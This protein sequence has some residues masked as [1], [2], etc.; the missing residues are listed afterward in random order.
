M[1][2]IEHRT[3]EQYYSSQRMLKEGVAEYTTADQLAM[4]VCLWP[5]LVLEQYPCVASVAVSNGDTRGQMIPDSRSATLLHAKD[6]Q[7]VDVV[8]AVDVDLYGEI[9]MS[10][11]MTPKEAA[12]FWSKLWGNAHE[13]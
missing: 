11:L 8:K 13:N 10:A 6:E 9:L 2:R 12:K 3:I 4:A 1:R 5:A 7:L